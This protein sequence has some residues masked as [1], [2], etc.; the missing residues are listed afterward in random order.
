MRPPT[1]WDF[2]FPTTK[3]SKSASL[4]QQ[5]PTSVTRLAGLPQGDSAGRRSRSTGSA[6][7]AYTSSFLASGY[8]AAID[9][10]FMLLLL[11][12]IVEVVTKYKFTIY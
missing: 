6:A 8:S 10:M 1:D 2:A 12:A 5:G 4:E 9:T 7:A 11:C 3:K